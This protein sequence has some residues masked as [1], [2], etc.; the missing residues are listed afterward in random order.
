MLDAVAA[1]GSLIALG[2]S[3]AGSVVPTFLNGLLA[4]L[5]DVR[6]D[7]ISATDADLGYGFTFPNLA[8]LR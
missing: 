6:N 8:M 4:A 3:H 2:R 1:D 7:L 5:D